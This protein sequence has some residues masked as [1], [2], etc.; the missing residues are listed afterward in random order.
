MKKK[1]IKQLNDRIQNVEELEQKRLHDGCR[2]KNSDLLIAIYNNFWSQLR[3]P[4]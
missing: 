1:A 2:D 3:L 4:V